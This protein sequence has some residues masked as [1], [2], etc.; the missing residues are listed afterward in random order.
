MGYFSAS[1]IQFGLFLSTVRGQHKNC[2]TCAVDQIRS[3]V[4]ALSYMPPWLTRTE[5]RNEPDSP[6]QVAVEQQLPQKTL[7]TFTPSSSICCIHTCCARLFLCILSFTPIV[8]PV[9]YSRHQSISS[10]GRDAVN[11]IAMAR[12]TSAT[13][14]VHIE[15]RIAL[16]Q[17][18]QRDA[19]RGAGNFNA[20]LL[21]LGV[22][23]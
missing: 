3:V 9:F 14:M 13:S 15:F 17:H 19:M 16:H 4:V 5:N 2:C 22:F 7:F 10:R 21:P 8:F 12:M 18:R 6:R 1:L 20:T 23:S 11:F